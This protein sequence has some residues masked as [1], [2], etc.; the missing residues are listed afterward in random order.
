MP[1]DKFK[2]HINE[3]KSHLIY[4]L[5]YF[6]GEPLLNKSF[7]KMV[8]YAK[9]Q[10]IYTA[11]STNGML[12]DD[13]NAKKVVESGLDR[14]IIS[15]DG[16]TQDT[17]EKYRQEGVLKDVL[18]GVQN[19]VR[20]KKE[21]KSATPYLIIQFLVMKHNEHQIPEI[22][23]LA[24]EMGADKLE[25]KS[26]QVYDYESGSELIPNNNKYA[27]YTKTEDGHWQLKKPIKN[28]CFRMWSGAVI[29]WDGRVVPCCFDKD[30]NHQMGSLESNSLKKIWKGKA[31]QAFRK[32]LIDDRKGIDICSN[33]TE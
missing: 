15:I 23:M 16:S 9:K 8:S 22:K 4:L 20:W 2:D 14:L 5:L 24:K 21:L 1:M 32:Q 11:T 19:V 28:R 17:Y 25:L 10:N 29:T 30:A 7:Y 27:R 33:C 6:Q 18:A 26:V 12:L 13:E 3:L 31:Y